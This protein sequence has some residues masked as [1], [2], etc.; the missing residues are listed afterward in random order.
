MGWVTIG[1][2]ITLFW[3]ADLANNRRRM[4]AAFREVRRS[5]GY[6][7]V[8]AAYRAQT[9]LTLHQYSKR[10]SGLV[11]WAVDD[12]IALAH[13]WQIPPAQLFCL[14]A[15]EFDGSTFAPLAEKTGLTIAE[16]RR[17]FESRRAA[18]GLSFQQLYLL[19]MGDQVTL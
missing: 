18:L 16:T 11:A 1:A 4:V 19:V 6:P 9:A 14:W 2:G 12:L 5:L 3:Q 13:D 17:R 8:D 15:E 7:T 10:E